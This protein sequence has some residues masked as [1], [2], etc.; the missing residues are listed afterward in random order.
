MT[1]ET[2]G[3]KWLSLEERLQVACYH[4]SGAKHPNWGLDPTSGHMLCCLCGKPSPELVL[5]VCVT[6]GNQFVLHLNDSRWLPKVAI[7]SDG[8]VIEREFE[9]KTCY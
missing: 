5:R 7:L 3:I 1:S 8:T 4:S 2:I 9:C 6:C